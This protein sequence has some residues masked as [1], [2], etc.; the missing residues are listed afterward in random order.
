MNVRDAITASIAR[1][2]GHP[3]GLRGRLVGLALNLSN[4]RFVNAAVQALQPQEADEVVDVGFGGGI[5]LTFLLARVGQSGLVHGV[6]ISDTMLAAAAS[7]YRRDIAAGRLA[8]HEGSMTRLPFADRQLSGVVSVNTIY[9]VPQL[10]RAF[11][12]FAR[13]VKSSG[14]IVIGLADPA[15]MAKMPP[16]KHGFRLRPVL[17]VIETLRA[18]GLTVEHRRIDQGFPAFHLLIGTPNSTPS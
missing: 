17:E 11:A 18:A 4:R 13:V 12:E 15:A 6:E 7:R 8:L 16:T 3:R 14:R 1:Q 9:F 10:D 5:G 2:L